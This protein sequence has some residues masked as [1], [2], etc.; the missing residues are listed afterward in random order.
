MPRE[1]QHLTRKV[2][3][4]V[5]AIRTAGTNTRA[6]AGD[7]CLGAGSQVCHAACCSSA[8]RAGAASRIRAIP[9]ATARQLPRHR[10][11]HLRLFEP[12]LAAT[13]GESGAA[14]LTARMQAHYDALYA[15][16]PRPTHWALRFH[17][18]LQI[19]PG[20]ALYRTVREEAAAHG[21]DPAAALVEAGSILARLDV[22]ARVTWLLR[23]VPGAV[24][25]FRR[26]GRL[27]LILYP[28]AGWDISMRENS[29]RRMA[30]DIR[31]CF[32]L[33]TLTAF[34][35]PELTPHFCQLDDIAYG[36]LPPSITWCRTTTLA[37]GGVACDFC[38]RNTATRRPARS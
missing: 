35:A 18:H 20:L 7:G 1:A 33:D 9:G 4:H 29:P 10:K 12:T 31:W 21:S 19:L 11:P 27:T 3:R 2:A 15:A 30:F 16:V 24:A 34:G 26:L 37:R 25:L 5:Y 38:W 32:Y 36:T 28:A 22:L 14:A 17:L 6:G 8:R 13:R 23:F